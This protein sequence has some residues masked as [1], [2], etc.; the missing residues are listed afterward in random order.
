M[1][2]LA[3]SERLIGSL[4][5][6]GYFP[7]ADV[8]PDLLLDPIRPLGTRDTFASCPLIS[9][10]PGMTRKMTGPGAADGRIMAPLRYPVYRRIWLASLISN[11]GLLI[12]GVGAAWAMTELASSADIVAL[13]QTALMLP[14]MLVAIP[15]GAA[16]DMYDRR[17][18]IISALLLSLGGASLLSALALL[19]L[20]SPPLLL[21]FTFIIGGGMALFGPAWQA[22]VS[23]QVPAETL[24]SAIALNSISFNIARSFGP[25]I[26]GII[27]ATAGAKVTEAWPWPPVR[28]PR[29]SLLVDAFQAH[30]PCKLGPRTSQEKEILP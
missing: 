10:E 25:A 6:A 18:V 23:E 20:V 15:A 29:R 19:D 7:K 11:L 4:M 26:G 5:A 3:R 1:S 28:R 2:S 8:L 24:P 17:V 9:H 30:G 16:A 12:Q 13:V 14:V 21:L 27:V 22:S